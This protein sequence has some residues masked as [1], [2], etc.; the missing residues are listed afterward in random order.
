MGSGFCLSS[1]TGCMLILRSGFTLGGWAREMKCEQPLQW[2]AS[3]SDHKSF[4]WQ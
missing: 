3:L 2:N 1:D 4:S